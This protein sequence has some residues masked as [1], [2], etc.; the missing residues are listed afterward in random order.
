MRRDGAYSD[1]Y[2]SSHHGAAKTARSCQSLTSSVAHTSG[3]QIPPLTL[4]GS[5]SA[6]HAG[7]RHA[8]AV[9]SGVLSKSVEVDS[10]VSVGR[11]VIGKRGK[12]SGSWSGVG[13]D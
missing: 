5:L 1:P 6:S 13:G 12:A 9:A 8:T 2:H 3:L 4:L 11:R 7:S 10:T